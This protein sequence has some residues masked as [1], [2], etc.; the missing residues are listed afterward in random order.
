MT[1]RLQHSIRIRRPAQEVFDYATAP[2]RWPEWHPSS[3]RLAPGAE[4]PLPAG[5]RFEEDIAAAGGRKAHLRW[6]VTEAVTPSLWRA[7]AEADNGL[8][9]SLSYQ[10]LA[11]DH[12]TRF[13]R[14]LDYALASPWLRALNVI[15]LRWLIARESAESL[16]RLKRVIEAR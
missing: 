9:L 3:L 14:T 2:A 8:T 11:E 13:V 1:T 10:F 12:G 6:I 4:K 7:Q 5:A 15:L 16:Q